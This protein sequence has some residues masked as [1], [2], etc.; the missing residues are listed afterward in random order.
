M[1]TGVGR[2]VSGS[3]VCRGLADGVPTRLGWKTGPLKTDPPV[4]P[5]GPPSHGLR[6][7]GCRENPEWVGD[8]RNLWPLCRLLSVTRKRICQGWVCVYALEKEEVAGCQWVL[9]GVA[10][11]GRRTGSGRGRIESGL[12]SSGEV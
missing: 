2:P 6:R 10:G 8:P 9:R 1:K 4:V 3:A 5:L 11:L 7:A 12:G